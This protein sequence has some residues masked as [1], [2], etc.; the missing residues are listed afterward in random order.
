[1]SPA[2]DLQKHVKYRW[3]GLSIITSRTKKALT[4][5][6]PNRSKGCN[7][8]TSGLL[9]HCFQCWCPLQWAPWEFHFSEAGCRGHRRSCCHCQELFWQDQQAV[10]WKHLYIQQLSCRTY[11]LH[12]NHQH[13]LWKRKCVK[14]R[15]KISLICGLNIH[16]EVFFI[17]SHSFKHKDIVLGLPSTN[18]IP[19]PNNHYN[20]YCNQTNPTWP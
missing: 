14:Y 18:I 1:M 12:W 3:A 4:W 10:V 8:L 7:M 13:Q 15:K 17:C 16:I 19:G 6:C 11:Q 20:L 2:S 9:C 5:H